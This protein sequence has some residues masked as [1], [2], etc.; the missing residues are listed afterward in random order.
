MQKNICFID[1]ETTGADLYSDHPIQLGAVLISGPQPIILKEFSSFIKPPENAKISRTAFKVHKIHIGDLSDAPAPDEVLKT[2][3]EQMGFDYS[4]GGWNINFDVSFFRRMCYEHG[5]QEHFQK[6]SHR[7]I[8]VQSIARALV[9]AGIFSDHIDSLSSL[10]EAL[11]IKRSEKHSALED[12]RIVAK[13]YIHLVNALG[14]MSANMKI[15]NI[16]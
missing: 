4:F 11:R 10:C 5:Y 8:D 1:F 6:I 3:F 14:Q 2:F 13:V 7:H 9:D 16:Y 12:A 15:A